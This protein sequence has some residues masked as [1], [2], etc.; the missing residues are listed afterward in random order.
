M[1]FHHEYLTQEGLRVTTG[2]A[3]EGSASSQIGRYLVGAKLVFGDTWT[4]EVHD[5]VV[6]E[7][8]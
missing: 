2:A 8:T 3:L 6:F 4:V 7:A 5:A 1:K